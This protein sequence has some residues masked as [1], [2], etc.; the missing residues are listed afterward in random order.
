MEISSTWQ[1][2]KLVT[3]ATGIVN[4][5]P[6]KVLNSHTSENY[7]SVIGIE[8]YTWFHR[9]RNHVACSFKQK[10]GPM[11]FNMT[12]E[13]IIERYPWDT[14]VHYRTLDS[15]ADMTGV[16]T[17]APVHDRT[18]LS[19]VQE[20]NVPAALR[21]LPIKSAVEKKVENAYKAYM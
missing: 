20:L 11:S 5:S 16:W 6:D 10:I 14:K 1:N 13:K 21:W 18:S 2:G 8:K 9:K 3:K 7:A 12:F 15:V 4:A 19:L 17:I